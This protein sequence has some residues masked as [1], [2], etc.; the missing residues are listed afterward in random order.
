[1]F[2]SFKKFAVAAT[3]SVIGLVLVSGASAAVKTYNLGGGWMAETSQP[4]VDIVVDGV[5]TDNLV[6]SLEK[7][8]TFSDANIDPFTG[9]F[10]P[11]R[12]TF[13]Q[14]SKYKGTYANLI[15]L[16]DETIQNDS[17]KTWTGF[18]MFLLGGYGDLGTTQ[19]DLSKTGGL[20]FGGDF[21]PFSSFNITPDNRSLT[22]GDGSI[23]PSSIWA[24]GNT[25]GN[26]NLVIWAAPNSA[27]DKSFVLKEQPIIAIPLPAAAWSGLSGLIG[28][29][30][31]GMVRKVR[32]A[33]D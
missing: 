25:A 18:K 24:P 26:T 21:G 2:E 20:P 5:S 15:V 33:R 12:I 27:G 4:N 6:I 16:A 22:F 11:A 10:D 32:A 29:G 30:V 7:F 9:Q 14:D 17:S 23:A 8:A 3:A 31:V 13:F 19:F 28:L 1:M